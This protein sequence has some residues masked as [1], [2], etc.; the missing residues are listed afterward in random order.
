MADKTTYQFNPIQGWTLLSVLVTGVGFPEGAVRVR[1]NA[2]NLL[3]AVLTVLTEA[4]AM[5][6]VVLAAAGGPVPVVNPNDLILG[7]AYKQ[8]MKLPA[9]KSSFVDCYQAAYAVAR[10]LPENVTNPYASDVELFVPQTPMPQRAAL[11]P[12]A[13]LTVGVIGVA[14]AAAA[15]LAYWGGKREDAQA[16]VQVDSLRALAAVEL[17]QKVAM[18]QVAK[19]EPLDPAIQ[20]LLGDLGRQR[21]VDRSWGWPVALGGAAVLTVGAGAA[22]VVATRSKSA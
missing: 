12:G 6:Q 10:W 17:A 20:T 22:V 18:A 5:A 13:L 4:E 1:L 19:G 21:E 2:L 8:M 11:T 7:T 14:A 16:S 3:Q 15:A 9:G